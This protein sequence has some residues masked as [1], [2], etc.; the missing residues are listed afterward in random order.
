MSMKMIR[1]VVGCILVNA[2][3]PAGAA[4]ND[5][6]PVYQHDIGHTGYVHQTLLPASAGF[7]WSQ[8][9]QYVQPSGLAVADG[10]VVTDG[11]KTYFI[12]RSSH[13][14]A[15]SYSIAGHLAYADDRVLIA[16]ASGIVTAIRVPTDELFRNAFE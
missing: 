15:A 1:L 7:L 11:V 14:A 4:Q 2:M 3:T 9:G 12:D 8:A 10:I 13:F 5:S 16:G 6:W